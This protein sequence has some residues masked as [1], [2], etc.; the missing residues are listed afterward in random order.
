MATDYTPITNQPIFSFSITCM[1]LSLA[2]VF[3]LIPWCYFESSFLIFILTISE[4][5]NDNYYLCN[6]LAF[7]G[8]MTFCSA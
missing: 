3:T 2:V 1:V 6:F 5:N 8:M 7:T 4:Y